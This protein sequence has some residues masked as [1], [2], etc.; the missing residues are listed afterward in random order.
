LGRLIDGTGRD[1]AWPWLPAWT[2]RPV[3]VLGMG[4]LA[5]PFELIAAM[6]ILVLEVRHGATGEWWWKRQQAGLQTR[7]DAAIRR[8]LP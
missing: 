2:L 1:Y 8:W 6:T 3:L 4:V 5:A 7:M